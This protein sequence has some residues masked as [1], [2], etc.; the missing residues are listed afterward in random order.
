MGVFNFIETFFFISL[1]ITFVLILLL[2]YH[3][4]QRLNTIEQ[5]SNTM[6]EIINN[7]VQEITMI[8]KF[9]LQPVNHVY[10][11]AHPVYTQP[12]HLNNIQEFVPSSIP[13]SMPNYMS[14]SMPNSMPNL[15]EHDQYTDSE[16]D[17]GDG[18]SVSDESTDGESTDGESDT[19][20]DNAKI[21]VSDDDSII[22]TII[23]TNIKVIQIDLDEPSTHELQVEHT[24]I[25]IDSLPV[26]DSLPTYSLPI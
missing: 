8:K 23:K 10:S 15:N 22:K 2:V 3:F 21:I 14:N 1:G 7:V 12:V 24:I 20:L 4:K 18:E 6:F 17:S 13:S 16:S 26:L 9:C 19:D 11:P 5:K 25:K